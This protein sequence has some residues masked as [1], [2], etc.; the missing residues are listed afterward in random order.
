MRHA[1][2]QLH[3]TRD[4]IR[5]LR[6]SNHD[7]ETQATRDRATIADLSARLSESQQLQ[8]D[9]AETLRDTAAQLEVMTL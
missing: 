4:D 2:L 3:A 9:T 6:T 8:L 1:T 5:M 7:L